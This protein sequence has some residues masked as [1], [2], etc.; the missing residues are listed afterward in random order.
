M[1][2]DARNHEPKIFLRVLSLFLRTKCPAHANL[3]TVM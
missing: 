1:E 3:L 2:D